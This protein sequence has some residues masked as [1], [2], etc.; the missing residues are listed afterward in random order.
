MSL[1]EVSPEQSG[2]LCLL[3]MSYDSVRTV[4]YVGSTLIVHAE[5]RIDDVVMD[6]HDL[7]IDEGGASE[8]IAA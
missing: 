7:F 3:S 4:G 2:T 8:L 5:R 6:S 1:F